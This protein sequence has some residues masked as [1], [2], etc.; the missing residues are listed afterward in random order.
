M[1]RR[2]VRGLIIVLLILIPSGNGCKKEGWNIEKEVSYGSIMS[3]YPFNGQKDVPLLPEIFIL[4]S[5]P[6]DK[7]SILGGFILTSGNGSISGELTVFP[8]QKLIRF[9]PAA[10]LDPLVEY[11]VIFTELKTV[12]GRNVKLFN[13]NISSFVTGGDRA[14]YTD[15]LRVISVTPEEPEVFDFSTFRIVFSEPLSDTSVVS[16]DTFKFVRTSTGEIVDGTL[17]VEGTKL[18]FDPR[19]D[20]VGGEEYRIELTDGIIGIDGGKLEPVSITFIPE[21]TGSHRKLNLKVSPD[22]D[23]ARLNLKNLPFSDLAGIPANTIKI[24][25]KIIGENYTIMKGI[26]VSEMADPQMFE[27]YIPVVIRKGQKIKTSNLKIKLGGEIDTILETGDVYLT[28]ITDASGVIKGNPFSM[29]NKDAPAA[30]FITL[31]VCLTAEKNMVNSILNQDTLNVQFFGRVSVEGDNMVIETVGI[32]EIEVMGAERA[33]VTLSMRMVTTTEEP[34]NDHLPLS[35]ST[36]TPLDDEESVPVETPVVIVFN[37]PLDRRAI[38]DRVGIYNS[39]IKIDSDITIRGA[40]VIIRPLTPLDYNTIYTVEI[41]NGIEDI[42]G[43]VLMDDYTYNFTTEVF[44]TDSPQAPLVSSMYPG[45]PCVLINPEPQPPGNAG[46]C[47]LSD[48]DSLKFNEFAMPEGSDIVVYFTKLLDASTVNENSF[49][50]RK[51]G[52]TEIVPGVRF[53]SGKKVTFVPDEKW[54]AG[55]SYELVLHGGTDS[56]CDP[57][58]I[59]DINGIPLNTDILMDGSESPGGS[60]III[61]FTAVNAYSSPLIALTLARYT[62]TNSNGKI[63]TSPPQEV[64]YSENSVVIRNASDNTILGTTYLSGTLISLIKGYNQKNGALELETVPGN[65]MFGTSTI[66]IILNSERMVM[67]PTGIAHGY[68]SAPDEQDYDKRPVLNIDMELWMNAV[69]DI[70]DLALEDAPKL[71]QLEG[72][73]DFLEDGRMSVVLQNKNRIEITVLGG[74]ITLAINPGDVNV[75]VISSPRF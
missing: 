35:I 63:D 17:I 28:L 66:I 6:M 47:F 14:K 48:D 71:M 42:N 64:S 5:E 50:I 52:T 56:S 45:V 34:L 29:Y 7:D 1:E 18:I 74:L 9:V 32:T 57:G 58:E 3:V 21:S 60:D 8:E 36:V 46:E 59:C 41:K 13:N 20:L 11:S 31:D 49:Y 65:W 25:S 73:V 19:E 67:R 27:D 62:D 39:S 4:F 53:I 24:N 16:G 51:K 68:I 23:D 37:N 75:R 44:N 33:P 43:S 40:S 26:L 15:K 38:S 70:A 2:M 30:V 72:R 12:D 54:I 10:K 61:P 55:K 69:N 22:L